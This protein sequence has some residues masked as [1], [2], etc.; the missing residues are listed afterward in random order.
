MEMT[1]STPSYA[2]TLIL[3]GL[4]T[5]QPASASAAPTPGPPCGDVVLVGEVRHSTYL[6][7][8]RDGLNGL[9]KLDIEVRRVL[10][11][12]EVGRRIVAVSGGEGQIRSDTPFVFVLSEGVKGEYGVLWADQSFAR[13]NGALRSCEP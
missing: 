6:G 1:R 3:L 4:V 10:R 8:E 13:A 11:G 12:S 5:S 9:W 2:M 7:A